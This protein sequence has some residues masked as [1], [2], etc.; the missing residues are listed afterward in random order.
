MLQSKLHLELRTQ[1]DVFINYYMGYG[2]CKDNKQIRVF[3]LFHK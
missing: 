2:I 1:T 3:G